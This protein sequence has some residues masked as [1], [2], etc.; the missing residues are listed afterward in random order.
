MVKLKYVLKKI[1]TLKLEKSIFTPSKLKL[2]A[3]QSSSIHKKNLS[4]SNIQELEK[5]KLG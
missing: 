3:E 2:S 1:I 5:L 4:L